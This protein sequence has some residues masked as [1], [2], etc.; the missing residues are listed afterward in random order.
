MKDKKTKDAQITFRLTSEELERLQKLADK[1][2][3]PRHR[4]IH[5]LLIVG[6]DTLEDLEKIG[7]VKAALLA[8]TAQEFVKERI[9]KAKKTDE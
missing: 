1:Y 9:G 6:L 4:F 5:N 7:V 2:E 3:I 8:R